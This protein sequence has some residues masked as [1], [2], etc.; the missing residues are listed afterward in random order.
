MRRCSPP[1]RVPRGAAAWQLLVVLAAL[2]AGVIAGLPMEEKLYSY[3]WRDARFCNDCH[4]HDYAN[5]AWEESAHG[6]LTTCHDC[7]RVPIRHYPRNLINTIFAPPQSEDDIHPPSLP[8][9]I[10]AQC[11]F[12]EGGDEPLTGPMPD[13]LRG[14]VVHVD[15]S[16]LHRIH[17]D[18][19][20]RVP[21][22]ES[23]QHGEE[24]DDTAAGQA[25]HNSE[26]DDSASHG[27]PAGEASGGHGGHGEVE[28][29][30]ITCMDCHGAANNRA[31][32]FEATAENCLRCHEGREPEGVRSG[33]LS[34]SECHLTGFLG[35]RPK[36]LQAE[37]KD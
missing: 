10:C 25:G 6:E 4:V 18:A 32:Q 22:G 35:K 7:H 20:S 30:P 12:S 2:A 19:D 26:G 37:K 17:L 28:E 24:G 13:E 21:R 5:Q 14:W 34:C 9:V 1:P 36:E 27:G 31:H 8:T 15:E 16:P 11:H 29:G 3:M 23:P 33:R